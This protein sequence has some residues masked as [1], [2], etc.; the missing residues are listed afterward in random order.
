M[1]NFN[2]YNVMCLLALFVFS[3]AGCEKEEN[4]TNNG[5]GSDTPNQEY[6]STAQVLRD[7]VTDIDGNSYDAVKI[8]N[9]VWMAENLRTT[10]YADGTTIPLATFPT[11]SNMISYRYETLEYDTNGNL[12][13]NVQRKGYLYNWCAVMN[14]VESGETNPDGIQGICPDGWH[15]P[16]D[17]EW[18][19]LI[20]CMS[21]E[22][23][24]MAGGNAQHLAKALA[25]TWGWNSVNTTDAV[26][27][28]PDL[29]N[30]T[31]F[32]APP[33]RYY[34][35]GSTTS[36]AAFFW[37]STSEFYNGSLSPYPCV[38]YFYTEDAMVQR[39]HVS[40]NSGLS[41]RCIRD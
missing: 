26:G 34:L 40:K 5:G 36:F 9:Q 17:A 21:H 18:T 37:S 28:N 39:E 35:D 4:N 38:R 11:N 8:G 16:N 3:L 12:V 29:N 33:V 2:L 27:N 22:S 31:G 23:A 24:Y 41:V 20:D 32:S 13:N 6:P 25:T 7:A 1:R 10:R 15:V 14:G 19:Q 30:A